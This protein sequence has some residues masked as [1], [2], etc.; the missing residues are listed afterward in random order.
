MP[1]PVSPRGQQGVPE[2]QVTGGELIESY[3]EQQSDCQYQLTINSILLRKTK[4]ELENYAE[5]LA[6]RDVRIAELE[7]ENAALKESAAAVVHM[8]ATA[9]E[10]VEVPPRQ[11]RSAA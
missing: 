9:G 2:I 5:A 6:Q 3:R 7:A 4:A 10:V 8:E 11:K 1:P